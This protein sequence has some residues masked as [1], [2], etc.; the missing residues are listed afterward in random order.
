MPEREPQGKKDAPDHN[1]RAAR[2]SDLKKRSSQE[3][4]SGDKEVPAPSSRAALQ[5]LALVHRW[6]G[7][8]C[9]AYNQ[10]SPFSHSAGWRLKEQ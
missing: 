9:V 6:L 2:S 3:A 5:A 10:D 8:W 4:G 1:G 7:Q